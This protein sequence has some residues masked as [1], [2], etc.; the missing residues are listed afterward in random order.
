MF[1]L[2]EKYAPFNEGE[3]PKRLHKD[4]RATLSAERDHTVA[5]ADG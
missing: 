5:G 4:E 2:I 3:G 1:Y